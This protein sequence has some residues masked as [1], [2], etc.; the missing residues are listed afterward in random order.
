MKEIIFHGRGG[1]GAKTASQFLANAAFIEGKDVQSFP[2]YGPER[3]GA[4]VVAYTRISD[5][6]IRI[7]SPIQQADVVVV[8]DDSLLDFVDIMKQAKENAIVIV[9]SK[10]TDEKKIAEKLTKPAQIYF[11][12]ASKISLEIMGKDF[13]NIPMLG[14]LAKATGIVKVDSLKQAIKEGFGAK[15]KASIIE[16]NYKTLEKGFELVVKSDITSVKKEARKNEDWTWKTLPE[17]GDMPAGTSSKYMTGSWRVKIPVVKDREK[18][19]NVLEK[20]IINCPEG[21]IKSKNGKFL[22]IDY[23]YCKGCGICANIAGK[24]II[25][26]K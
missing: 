11:L 12:N 5:K 2:E 7:H 15:G 3:G 8:I 24:D 4:P 23:R 20:I 14:A 1:H 21:A 16:G 22:M 18:I 10:N 9:N 13:A 19:Q 25:E 26:M 6:R 17:A